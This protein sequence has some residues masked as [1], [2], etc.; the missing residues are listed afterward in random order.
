MVCGLP[1]AGKTTLARR[2]EEDLGAVRL[3]PDDWLQALGFDGY[4]QPARG[5]V[6]ALQWALAKRL[7]ASGVSVVLENGF[8]VRAERERLRAEA[9][10]AG[11]ETRL[12]YLDVPLAE[13]KRRVIARNAESP[14]HGFI[15]DPND[16][17]VWFAAFEAP[18]AEELS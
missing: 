13:L 8:W 17:D 10:G 12:H 14:A 9:R 6:E 18:T 16:V 2:L 15:V 4:D 11:A 3:C 7:L 5:R 1:G